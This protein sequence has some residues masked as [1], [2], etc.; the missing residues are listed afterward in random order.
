MQ[1]IFKVDPAKVPL[2]SGLFYANYQGQEIFSL[3]GPSGGL[4]LAA[5]CYVVESYPTDG[6]DLGR[7]G[8]HEDGGGRWYCVELSPLDG[9]E[10]LTKKV[11]EA[12][13]ALKGN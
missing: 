1:P 2:P 13:A 5:I 10:E 8:L 7:H 4:Q 12:V 3:R 6:R 9:L 11:G